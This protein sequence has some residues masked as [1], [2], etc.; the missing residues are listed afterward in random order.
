MGGQNSAITHSSAAVVKTC[1]KTGV[2]CSYPVTAEG[3][4]DKAPSVPEELLVVYGIWGGRS[5]FFIWVVD[6]KLSTCQ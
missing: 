6:G 4:A 5:R 2:V 3:G 1:A